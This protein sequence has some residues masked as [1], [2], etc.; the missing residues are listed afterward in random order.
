V[1]AWRPSWLRPVFVLGSEDPRWWRQYVSAVRLNADDGELQRIAETEGASHAEVA[2]LV[3]GYLCE[4]GEGALPYRFDKAGHRI[5][6]LAA[7]RRRGYGACGDA[8]AAISAALL[9]RDAEH[10]VCYEK[11]DMLPGYAH[12]RIVIG[13]HFADAYPERSLALESCA[14]RLP[15]TRA[16]VRWPAAAD[17]TRRGATDS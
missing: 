1:T 8:C 11:T 16:R 3:A 14:A 4:Q 13:S 17:A 6:E 5:I 15:V 9:M 2:T 10:H 12:V 7:A